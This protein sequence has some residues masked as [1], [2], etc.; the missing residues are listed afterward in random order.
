MLPVDK[1]ALCQLNKLIARCITAYDN[2]EFHIV[3]HAIHNF[4]VVDMSNFYLD[5]IK[6]RL[7]CDGRTSKER[8]SGQ[9]AIYTILDALVRLLAPILSFT[10]NEI[11]LAMPHKAGDNAEHVMLN[12]LYKPNPAWTLDDETQ[13]TWDGA[14]RLRD[15]VNKAL[16]IARGEKTIGK[17]LDAKV[18]LYV[19]DAAKADFDRLAGLNFKTLFITSAVDVVCGEGD[20]YAGVQFPGITVKIEPCDAPKCVRCWTRDPGVG[21]DPAHPELC[22]RCAAAIQE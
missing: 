20:G 2:Y 9:S 13:A 7:Y 18:T 19:S 6:D 10:A 11:W 16:E 21:S 8:L 12:D 15:D 3:T 14:L 17:P 4:C 5:I 1:W 22:P